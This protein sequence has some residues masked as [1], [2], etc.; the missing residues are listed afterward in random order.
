MLIITFLT[1][2][3]NISFSQED[4][5]CKIKSFEAYTHDSDE[6]SNI[7]ESPGGV[8]ILKINTSY[9]EGCVV[10]II[11]FEDGWFKIDTISAL[12]G[13]EVTNFQGWIHSSI[14]GASTTYDLNLV[15][16]P[17]G[18]EKVGTIKGENG[19]TFKI[20]DVHCEWI[21]IKFKNLAGW[22]KSEK[23]CGSPVTNCS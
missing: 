13:Y 20:I 12:S 1:I 15:D 18:K 7:R 23:I 4:N 17:N 21:K 22:V 2:L 8:V 16:Q 3:G 5:A 19:H 11:D 9:D 10:N 14:I 6:F